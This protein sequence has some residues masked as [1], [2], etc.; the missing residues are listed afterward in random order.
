[1]GE[2][3]RHCRIGATQ[4]DSRSTECPSVVCSGC[5]GTIY[6]PTI[7][8]DRIVSKMIRVNV[9]KS[10]TCCESATTPDDTLRAG[11]VNSRPL[12][13]TIPGVLPARTHNKAQL[14]PCSH[15]DPGRVG[16][17][18]SQTL[19]GQEPGCGSGKRPIL[20]VGSLGGLGEA[21]I[22]TRFGN[23]ASH[24]SRGGHPALTQFRIS[25]NTQRVDLPI[26]IGRGIL[27]ASSSRRIDATERPR[28]F[29][30]ARLS[31]SSG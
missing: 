30:T 13:R 28:S 4:A 14:E 7:D 26:A 29:E 2:S 24:W 31:I 6:R 17:L 18:K 11:L 9:L 21:S 10:V 23:L 15:G 20:I 3:R 27:P 19:R 1:M 5:L 8:Q 25:F 16:K 12:L 22:D